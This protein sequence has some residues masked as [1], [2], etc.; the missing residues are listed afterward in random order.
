MSEL[1]EIQ[2]IKRLKYKYMRCLDNKLWDDLG[3]CFIDDA[4]TSYSDGKLCFK[5]RDEIIGFLRE[6]MPPIIITMHQCIQPEIDLTSDVDATGIWAF[7]DYLIETN[8]NTS[9]RGYGFYHDEYVK[10]S[11]EWKI[12][13]TGYERVFEETWERGNLPSLTLTENKFA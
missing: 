8:S 6:A 3:T 7:H 13:E 10:V 11:G 1:L 12:K 4:V 9:L 5:G 2:M